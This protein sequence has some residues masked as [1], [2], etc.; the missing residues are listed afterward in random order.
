MLWRQ[1][2]AWSLLLLVVRICLLAQQAL[3]LPSPHRLQYPDSYFKEP[4]GVFNPAAVFN[5]DVGWVLVSRW[6]QCFYRRCGVHHTGTTVSR[7]AILYTSI[8]SLKYP[9]VHTLSAW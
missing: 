2:Q 3:T 4:S 9:V 1:E 6:D 8:D 5:S 7:P